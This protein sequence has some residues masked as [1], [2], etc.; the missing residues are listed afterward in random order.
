MIEFFG[1]GGFKAIDLAALRID[2]RHNVLDGAV[3]ARRMHSLKDH[4]ERV[5]V[6]GI[7]QVLQTR[8]FL[9]V[10]AQQV[11]VFLLRLEK[12]IHTSWQVLEADLFTRPDAKGLSIKLD[13]FG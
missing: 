7:H 5:A 13:L 11:S 12:R 9:G 8:E 2:A 1:S 10:L 6:R 4:Q 3:L